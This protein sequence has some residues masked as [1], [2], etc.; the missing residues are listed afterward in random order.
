MEVVIE[1]FAALCAVEFVEQEACSM[2]ASWT[3]SGASKHKDD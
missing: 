1:T 2:A 3:G